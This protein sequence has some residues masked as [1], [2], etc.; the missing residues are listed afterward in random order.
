MFICKMLVCRQRN[1]ICFETIRILL[2]TKDASTHQSPLLMLDCIDRQ[3]LNAKLFMHFCSSQPQSELVARLPKMDIYYI[4]HIIYLKKD[5]EAQ[6][7]KFAFTVCFACRCHKIYLLEDFGVQYS[8][9]CCHALTHAVIHSR[10]Q[11]L[12]TQCQVGITSTLF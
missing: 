1:I 12:L 4:K 5:N 8:L 3:S 11:L 9:S 2:A 10:G 7:S 6:P